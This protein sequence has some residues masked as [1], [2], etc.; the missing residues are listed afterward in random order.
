MN[1]KGNESANRERWAS[2]LKERRNIEV[3]KVPTF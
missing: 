2:G 3:E 1:G